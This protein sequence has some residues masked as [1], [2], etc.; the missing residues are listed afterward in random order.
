MSHKLRGFTLVELMVVVAIIALLIGL[1]TVAIGGMMT[2]ARSTKDLAN[3]KAIGAAT[4]SHAADHKGFLLHP[5]TAGCQTGTPSTASQAGR[6]WVLS[7]GQ[8][9]DGFDRV[10]DIDGQYVEMQTVLRDGAA[11]PYIGALTAFQSPLDPTIGNVEEFVAGHPG[12]RPNRIRSYS[13]NGFVGV[14]ENPDDWSDACETYAF[15][16]EVCGRSTATMSQVPQP[17]STMCS[18][19]E[20]DVDGHNISGWLLHPGRE[21]WIDFPAF[22]EKDRVNI[23]FIDASTGSIPLKHEG[24][25]E[26]WLQYGHNIYFPDAEKEYQAFKKVLLPGVIKGGGLLD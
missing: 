3:H 8:D 17:S 5:R 11:F 19:G 15:P 7:D 4:S 10:L 18:V 13:L 26:R 20:Q 2:R 23:S 9:S 25:K 12:I 14:D 24:L 6:F 16:D 22:W 21:Q 1:V